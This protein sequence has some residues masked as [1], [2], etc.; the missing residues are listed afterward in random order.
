[1]EGTVTAVEEKE[2]SMQAPR[3][4]LAASGEPSST[5]VKVEGG[6]EGLTW[7]DNKMR[8]CRFI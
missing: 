5:E 8:S 3:E 7:E 6:I 4:L 1:M 2:V